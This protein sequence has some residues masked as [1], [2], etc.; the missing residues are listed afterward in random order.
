MA[1]VNA[2]ALVNEARSFT[3]YVCMYVCMY[4]VFAPI[5]KREVDKC[6]SAEDLGAMR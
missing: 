5:R 1:F 6:F 3:W 2:K 4:E